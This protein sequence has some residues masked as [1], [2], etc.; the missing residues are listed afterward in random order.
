MSIKEKRPKNSLKNVHYTIFA[1]FFSFSY[2]NPFTF[3]SHACWRIY[4]ELSP[5]QLFSAS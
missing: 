4:S 3:P 1:L 5:A 2:L